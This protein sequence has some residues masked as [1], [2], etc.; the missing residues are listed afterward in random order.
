MADA[1]LAALIRWYARH[2][3]TGTMTIPAGA[4]PGASALQ[5]APIKR[6]GHVDEQTNAYQR[7]V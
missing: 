6:G 5:L 7:V 4:G 2:P 1:F 3:G